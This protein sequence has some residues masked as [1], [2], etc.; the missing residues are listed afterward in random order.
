MGLGK[1]LKKAF[2][3][4]TK[5]AAKFDIAHQIG[6]KMGLPDPSGDLLYG[7]NRA[8]SPQEQQQEAMRRQEDL[9]NQQRQQEAA[10]ASQRM[11]LEQAQ[12]QNSAADLGRDNISNVV[13]GGSAL[14]FDAGNIQ[15]KKRRGGGLS[16][17]LG[18]G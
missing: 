15:Q 12:L 5:V 1:S 13:A 16:S 10:L 2:K 18:I 9:M 3:K 8:L 17:T 14:G 7:S 6:K 4:I 11:M